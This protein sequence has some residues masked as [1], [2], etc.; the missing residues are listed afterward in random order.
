MKKRKKL[1]NNINNDFNNL[2]DDEKILIVANIVLKKH[3]KAFK[4]LAKY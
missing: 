2:T 3:I 4:N 1:K